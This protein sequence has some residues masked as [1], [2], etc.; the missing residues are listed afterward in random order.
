MCCLH[1]FS[2]VNLRVIF[3]YMVVCCCLKVYLFVSKAELR[4]EREVDIFLVLVH[5]PVSTCAGGWS[6]GLVQGAALQVE[7]LRR[8]LVLL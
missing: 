3:V 4:R 6:S 1:S 5:S 2:M 8:E 7:P